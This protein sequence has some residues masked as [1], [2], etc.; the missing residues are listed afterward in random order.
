MGGAESLEAILDGHTHQLVL[1]TVPTLSF[2][3]RARVSP[4]PQHVVRCRLTSSVGGFFVL[5]FRPQDISGHGVPT[6]HRPEFIL[7]RFDTRL[8]RRLSRMFG[9]L[10]TPEPEFQGRRVVTF[11]NQ[12]DFVFVRHHRYAFESRD[13][14]VWCLVVVVLHQ[15]ADTSRVFAPGVRSQTRVAQKANLQE[16]GPRFTLKLKWMLKDTFNTEEGEYEWFHRGHAMDVS[17]RK[18]HL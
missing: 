2:V 17:R 12:R 6:D 3:E 5:G 15:S 14:R 1:P 18:F 9:S 11:H 16:L 8:G 7:N 10:Y 4:C 13:V